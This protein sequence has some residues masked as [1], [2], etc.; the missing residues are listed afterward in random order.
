M[1]KCYI[2]YD[3]G[4]KTQK[5]GYKISY[6]SLHLLICTENAKQNAMKVN[7]LA[8]RQHIVSKGICH[9]NRR[10][11]QFNKNYPNNIPHQ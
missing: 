9:R 5:T 4:P 10:N 7:L 6:G 8:R 11:I 3:L 1:I 2:K